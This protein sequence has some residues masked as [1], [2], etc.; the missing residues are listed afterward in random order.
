MKRRSRDEEGGPRKRR[1][2]GF[3]QDET[4]FDTDAGVNRGIALMDNQLLADHLA[5][6]T[7]RLGTDLSPIELSDLYISREPTPDRVAETT[8]LTKLASEF[9]SRYVFLAGN[10]DA[11]WAPRV[12]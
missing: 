8:N 10:A 3:E 7:S 6:K 5:Q 1:R 11:R 4:L 9:H 2:P 12:S